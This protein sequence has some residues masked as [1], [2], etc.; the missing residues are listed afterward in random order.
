MNPTTPSS[1][2]YSSFTNCKAKCISVDTS[3]NIT[4]DKNV[5]FSSRVFHVEV[6]TAQAFK[7][8]NNLMIG[9]TEKPSLEIGSELVACFATYSYVDPASSDVSVKNNFCSG[10][11]THGYVFPYIKCS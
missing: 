8:T 6:L 11:D 3:S 10:S 1:I 4:I 7:F 9:V 5:F 2:S